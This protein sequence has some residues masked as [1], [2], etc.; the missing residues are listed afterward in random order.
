MQWTYIVLGEIL[1]WELGEEV[2]GLDD[3]ARAHRPEPRPPAKGQ[4]LARH[5]RPNDVAHR[6]RRRWPRLH[7]R[8]GP[9]A[10][11]PSSSPAPLVAS[12]RRRHDR[13]LRLGLRDAALQRLLPPRV[14][15]SV[16]T[17]AVPR[18]RRRHVQ[19]LEHVRGRGQRVRSLPRQNN[20]VTASEHKPCK[21]YSLCVISSSRVAR[22]TRNES[23]ANGCKEP[24][25]KAEPVKTK[26]RRRGKKQGVEL[27]GARDRKALEPLSSGTAPLMRQAGRVDL[28]RTATGQLNSSPRWEKQAGIESSCFPQKKVAAVDES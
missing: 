8:L 13:R 10:P 7:C 1:I 17:P 19:D 11:P 14:T 20:A 28:L 2:V 12:L 23:C 15:V 22:Q 25:K 26:A 24:A 16:A 21:R 4:P 3:A 6:R 27:M 5:R 9:P 18:R